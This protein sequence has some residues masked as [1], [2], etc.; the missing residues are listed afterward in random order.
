MLRSI[1]SIILGLHAACLAHALS[2]KGLPVPIVQNNYCLSSLFSE[3]ESG[4]TPWNRLE[5]GA[6][7][8]D[9][10]TNRVLVGGS[11]RS[12]YALDA[13]LL[14]KQH[15]I[16]LPS[17]ASKQPLLQNGSIWIGTTQG[18]I[19]KLNASNFETQWQSQL[20][21]EL[22]GALVA[23]SDHLYALSGLATLCAFD[24]NT[25]D[26]IWSQKR[27]FSTGLSL[28]ALSSPILLGDHLVVGSPS[29]KLEF[30]HRTDGLLAFDVQLGDPQKAFS[31][32]AT[33]PLALPDGNL[34]AAAFN[35][36]ISIV[37]PQG[38][39][40]SNYEILEITHLAYANGILVAAGPKKVWGL[41]LSAQK[42]RWSFRF[43]KGNPTSVVIRDHSVFFASDQGALFVNHLRTGKPLQNIGSSYGYSSAF[44]FGS[45]GT[46]Y[47]LSNAGYL[48]AYGR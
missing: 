43:K 44:D 29:G 39:I 5:K 6:P 28:K 17:P 32:V 12:F 2:L 10:K 23:D 21:A 42:I 35:R 40:L 27:S 22:G 47:T 25:G 45:N 36:G 48:F 31:D 1:G 37:S 13:S 34:A 19:L 14:M 4:C 8:F 15:Q 11:D 9:A 26:E 33:T 20:D 24:L 3:P 7:I 38:V 18:E 46:L 16:S 30:Y 41:D